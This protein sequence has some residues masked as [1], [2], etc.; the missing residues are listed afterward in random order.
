MIAEE[1]SEDIFTTEAQRTRSLEGNER[2]MTRNAQGVKF[3][4]ALD[5][6]AFIE[7]QAEELCLKPLSARAETRQERS[8]YQ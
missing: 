4:P 7:C 1:G 2:L 5:V 8:P 3:L 6:P